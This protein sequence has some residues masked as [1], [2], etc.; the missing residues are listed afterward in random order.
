MRVELNAAL[1]RG[2]AFTSEEAGD[3]V[4]KTDGPLPGTF[5]S[6]LPLLSLILV[7]FIGSFVGIDDIIYYG[8][9]LAVILSLIFFHHYIPSHKEVLNPGVENSISPVILPAATVGFGCRINNLMNSWAEELRSF[10]FIECIS[11]VFHTNSRH[12]KNV[13]TDKYLKGEIEWQM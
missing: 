5:I 8:L 11:F 7:I 6:L 9:V 3:E 10:Y 1:E 4:E 13:S 2:D 12:T